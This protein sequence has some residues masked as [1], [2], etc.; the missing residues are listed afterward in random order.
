MG[1]WHLQAIVI[2][3]SLSTFCSYTIV[4]YLSVNIPLMAH[5]IYWMALEGAGWR[6]LFNLVDLVLGVV[7]PRYSQLQLLYISSASRSH[8]RPSTISVKKYMQS[9]FDE[10]SISA[11]VLQN[12]RLATEEE[13]AM[14]KQN[15]PRTI[16]STSLNVIK[17]EYMWC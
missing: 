1:Q 2:C 10:E 15:H 7:S 14:L 8:T 9:N 12:Y 17:S 5:P 13:I 16:P 6:L 4:T 11:W 3:Y